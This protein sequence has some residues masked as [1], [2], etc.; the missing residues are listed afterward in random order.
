MPAERP[1]PASFYD[2]DVFDVARDLLGAMVVTGTGDERVAV[3]LTEVEAYAGET[4]PGSHA[5]R[6]RTAR[7]ATM[8]GPP[9]QIYVYFTYGMHFC[10]NAVCGPVGI[11][12]AVLLRAG[13]VVGGR[14]V[15]RSRRAGIAERDWA[16]G[17]ARLTRTLAVDRSYDGTDVTD[18]SSSLRLLRG[19][20]V[21]DGTVRTGPRVG[22]GGAGAR[23]PW[24]FWVDGERSVSAYKPAVRRRRA[25]C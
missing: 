8:F 1:L 12:R 2:R 7:N 18:R 13:E 21:G 24:R 3:R 10:M 9:G 20:P 25:G 23:S 14:D 22:V 19:A 4:D 16:R 5:Y 11:A 17:P 15:A 6:G